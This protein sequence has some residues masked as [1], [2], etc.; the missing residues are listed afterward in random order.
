MPPPALVNGDD[1]AVRKGSAFVPDP[2]DGR[3]QNE[4]MVGKAQKDCRRTGES[5][6]KAG[7]DGID[8]LAPGTVIAY[9]ADRKVPDD[10]RDSGAVRAGHHND[11]TQTRL[12]DHVQAAPD[13][14]RAVHRQKLLRPAHP[15]RRARRKQDRRDVVGHAPSCAG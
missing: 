9:D 8:H 7:P 15:P 2:D 6:A 14:R 13:R 5:R 11:I 3:R 12:Q 4:R 10:L 1:D